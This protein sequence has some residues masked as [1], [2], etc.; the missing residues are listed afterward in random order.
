VKRMGMAKLIENAQQLARATRAA[1]EELGLQLFA[2][3]SP[4]SAVTA[5]RAPRGMDSGTIVKEFRNRFGTIITNGQ[6][7]MKGQ[8]FRIAHLG[9]FDFVDLF[10]L[11]AGL[12]II[13]QANGYRV[14]FG[15]GVAAVESVY[16]EVTAGEHGAQLPAVVEV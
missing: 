12:E 11:I 10:G 8:I 16:A 7:S 6:G 9:Y 2:P 5:V 14:E 15:K 1:V 3:G 13:L 4:G